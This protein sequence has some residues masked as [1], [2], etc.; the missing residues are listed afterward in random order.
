MTILTLPPFEA[1]ADLDE[2]PSS[3]DYTVDLGG[4]AYRIRLFY[5]ERQDRWYLDLFD[6]D[7]V[8]ILMGRIL[9][10]DRNLLSQ[11]VS[12]LSPAGDL[13]L[14]DTAESDIEC[15]FEG[16]GARCF[17]MWISDDEVTEDEEPD[18]DI[19]PSAG[20]P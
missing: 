6:A 7:D 15:G 13:V 1:A 11:Y 8:P 10:I 19:V 12:E 18:L 5:R 17:L 2:R 9:I 14:I 20:D 3:Y 4:N 16:L